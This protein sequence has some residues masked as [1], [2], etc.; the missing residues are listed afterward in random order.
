MNGNYVTLKIEGYKITMPITCVKWALQITKNEIPATNKLQR[1]L[2]T[3]R[4]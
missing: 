3:W 2:Q 4:G 1:G